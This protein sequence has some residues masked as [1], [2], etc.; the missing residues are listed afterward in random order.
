MPPSS[1]RRPA[2]TSPSTPSPHDLIRQQ[3]AQDALSQAGGFDVYIADQV[4]LP[5]F[6]EKGFIVDLTDK[7]DAKDKADF[8]GSALETVS[9][10]GKL[11][12]LPIIV[13]NCAM[14]YRTD[15]FEAAGLSAAPATWDEYR[16]SPRSSPTRA[17]GAR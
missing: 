14:Y 7:I 2:S 13:H 16:E 6:A 9:W 8:A 10:N 1:P 12:A 15:L 17:S 5:E 3:F 4:W 11:Y